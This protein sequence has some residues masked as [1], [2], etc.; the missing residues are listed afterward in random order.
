MHTRSCTATHAHVHARSRTAPQVEALRPA[1]A[2]PSATPSGPPPA[3]APTH[4]QYLPVRSPQAS[5]P[6]T[7]PHPSAPAA[8]RTP[9][10]RALPHPYLWHVPP[11]PRP[12]SVL[13]ALESV[14]RT[15]GVAALWR[16]NLATIMH[17]WGA[18]CTSG[19]RR[20]GAVHMV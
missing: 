5:A 19:P 8:S 13:R 4:P 9:H 6:P 15:E 14:V 12:P 1:D 10:P 20:F 7:P 18:A 11:P 16:G 17:R 2:P 3:H